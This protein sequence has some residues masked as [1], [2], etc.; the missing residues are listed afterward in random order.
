MGILQPNQEILETWRVDRMIGQ[1]AFAEVYRVEHQFMGYQAMKVFKYANMEQDVLTRYM[2][3]AVLLTKL[4]HPHVVR[5][6]DANVTTINQMKYAFFTMEYV[7]LGGL[8]KYWRSFGQSF[9]PVEEAMDIITQVTDGL[10][11][12][13]R[14][15]PPLIHRDIKPQNILIGFHEDRCHAWLSDFGL[16]RHVNPLTWEASVRGTRTFK[17]PEVTGRNGADSPAS[18]IWA[19]GV[20]A[21]LL[22]TDHFPFT[23]EPCEDLS[24]PEVVSEYLPP[25]HWNARVDP[26]LDEIVNGCLK[27]IPEAR[28]PNAMK[29]RA[30]LDTWWAATAT[31]K[32]LKLA[33]MS[34]LQEDPR[35]PLPEPI[36]DDE[37]AEH[38]ERIR[39]V[40]ERASTGGDLPTAARDLE[41]LIEG[42]AALQDE[43]GGF[44]ATWR[45]GISV[46]IILTTD[47][48]PSPSGP[49]RLQEGPSS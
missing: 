45:K 4:N 5:V 15:C 3:E 9:M 18:D 32:R 8:D 12:A 22:L 13:H 40:L 1:G 34:P 49:P 44:I 2:D 38:R 31:R 41:R 36:T 20:T 11:E 10:C 21:Y 43:F 42:D 26:Q 30:A 17:P 19:L 47:Q 16:A 27:E 6:Y 35:P 24:G 28:Y 14:L 39:A 25:S 48:K 46:P 37:K 33:D 29:F 23:T 7:P